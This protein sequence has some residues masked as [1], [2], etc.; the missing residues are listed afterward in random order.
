MKFLYNLKSRKYLLMFIDFLCIVG[1]C[2]FLVMLLNIIGIRKI[3][4]YQPNTYARI[5]LFALLN[6]IFMSIFNAYKTVWRYARAKDF[7]TCICGIAAATA[8]FVVI[9]EV[10]VD[11]YNTVYFLFSGIAS[12]VAVSLIRVMYAFLCNYMLV[13]GN[14]SSAKR[15]LIIGAGSAG[16][17]ICAMMQLDAKKYNPVAFVDDDSS[18]IGRSFN[19]VVIK[20][21][22]NEIPK[23]AEEMDISEIVLAIP[24]ASSKDRKR[25]LNICS[26]TVCKVSVLPDTDQYIHSDSLIKQMKSV[27]VE[28]LLGREVIKLDNKMTLNMIK[29]KV[30]L[31]TGGGGSIGSELVRQIAKMQPKQLII[32]DIYENNAYS[33]QQ[34]LVF[35]Y[36]DEL[37]LS[38]QIGSVRDIDKMEALFKEFKPDLVFHAAAH[39]HVPLMET[40]PEEAIKNNVFG[41]LNTAMLAE[42]YECEKFVL[43]STDKAVNP[44]NIM[45]ATKRCCEMVVESMAQDKP[46]TEF[47]AVRF[48]NV[49][50]SNGSAIPLF[51]T[52]IAKG[53]PV[54]VTDERII[55]Y[56]MTIPEAASLIL[57][58][59]TLARGGEIFVL[60]MG[61][62]VKI[63]EL[64]ENLIKLHGYQPYKEIDIKIIGLRPGE[65]LKEELLMDEEGLKN[66]ANNKIF[67]GHQIEVDKALFNEELERLHDAAMRNDKSECEKIMHEIVPTFKRTK[68]YEKE[69]A[70][71]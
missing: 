17:H 59:A 13:R 53:G 23:I 14:K 21:N 2:I 42:K 28:D 46:K 32:V 68:E 37:N 22:T 10:F 47:V 58:A 71:G 48:G 3:I 67:I 40:N 1:V 57:Q 31:V 34:E 25:I 16:T 64:A 51:E 36:G 19:G 26:E 39:K 63:I 44:T 49:L 11:K 65:K 12:V 8:I 41:T 55:R 60:D 52:Q 56:F 15:I 18:K 35:K 20:G 66:T 69:L 61:E 30:C 5:G 33:I 38:V 7:A 9:C 43:V 6:V 29:D 24:S 45:G 4:F 62:P 27:K 50:G 54:T 70:K